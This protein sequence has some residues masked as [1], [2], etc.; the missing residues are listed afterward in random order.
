MNHFIPINRVRYEAFWSVCDEKII[1]FPLANTR[2]VIINEID[3]I[4]I[5]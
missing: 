3:V 4:K 1:V 5:D 2:T